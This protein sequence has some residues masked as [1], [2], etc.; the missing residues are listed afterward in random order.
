[1]AKP[2]TS[3][4]DAILRENAHKGCREVAQM[5]GRTERSVSQHAKKVKV[6]FIQARAKAGVSG[7]KPCAHCGGFYTEGAGLSMHE[8]GC[9]ENPA[10]KPIAP[11]PAATTSADLLDSAALKSL[12]YP[13]QPEAVVVHPEQ[14]TPEERAGHRDHVEEYDP[15]GTVPSKEPERVEPYTDVTLRDIVASGGDVRLNL[16]EDELL[17]INAEQSATIEVLIER[18]ASLE[19]YRELPLHLRLREVLHPASRPYQSLSHVAIEAWAVDKATRR[20]YAQATDKLTRLLRKL[21][22]AEVAEVLSDVERRI[23]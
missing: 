5:L 6:S 22:P 7:K 20:R 9:K 11:K 4:E 2:W 16:M 1:M 15:A 12:P 21:S 13:E 10:N 19:S 23:A 3:E 18:I 14:A 8:R 17:D